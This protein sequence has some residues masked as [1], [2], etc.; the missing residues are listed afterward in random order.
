MAFPP[1]WLIDF[2]KKKKVKKVI[3]RHK[4]S[5][6][7]I[8]KLDDK[9]ERDR[10]RLQGE[11]SSANIRI[12]ELQKKQQTKTTDVARVL[13]KQEE[14][15][16]WEPY[17]GALSL[18]K[19]FMAVFKMKQEPIKQIPIRV[20]SHDMKKQFGW[21]YDIVGTTQGQLAIIIK[22]MEGNVTPL[23]AGRTFKDIFSNY[24]GISHTFQSGRVVSVNLDEQ[25]RYIQDSKE[26][27]VPNVIINPEGKIIR[28]YYDSD[29]FI[30]ILTDKEEEIQELNTYIETMESSLN[31]TNKA[32]RFE[33][34]SNKANKDRADTLQSDNT[35]MLQD[36]A[37][38]MRE[39]RRINEENAKMAHSKKIE[40]LREETLTAVNEEIMENMRREMGQTEFAK[41]EA[42]LRKAIE[43]AM[44]NLVIKQQSEP[45]VEKIGA[46]GATPA[47]VRR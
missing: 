7:D 18:K 16:F 4:L 24:G 44:D 27:E 46:S 25:G 22:D 32:Y 10:A 35:S 34:Q 43:F 3:V 28:N 45:V 30:K 17:K 19:L 37:S 5:E 47:G 42:K 21:L 8:E 12:K 2:F 15:L 11:L 6:G 29:K 13:R 40:E 14:D 1:K 33:K 26:V 39:W 9:T 41:A 38:V 31:K 23:I 36:N 20:L